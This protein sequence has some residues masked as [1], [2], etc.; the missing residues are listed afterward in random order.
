VLVVVEDLHDR[1]RSTAGRLDGA[2]GLVLVEH[3][4]GQRVA[5]GV[6]VAARH[7]RGALHARGA[8]GGAGDAAAAHAHPRHRGTAASTASLTT[9]DAAAAGATHA[10]AV[11]LAGVASARASERDRRR[12]DGADQELGNDR[13]RYETQPALAHAETSAHVVEAW[14]ERLGGL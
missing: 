13:R 9:G 4:A 1:L 8:R 12:G 11:V 6:R 3:D 5:A 2:Q 14:R 7:D 10:R